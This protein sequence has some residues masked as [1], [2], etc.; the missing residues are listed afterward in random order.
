MHFLGDHSD[1][2]ISERARIQQLAATLF[3]PLIEKKRPLFLSPN[4]LAEHKDKLLLLLEGQ[5]FGC[6]HGNTFASYGRFDLIGL[7]N[8]IGNDAFTV[9]IESPISAIALSVDELFSFLQSDA[10]RLKRW[11][12]WLLLNQSCLQI[13][14]AN[15]V[16]APFEPSAG[17]IHIKA[18]EAIIHEGDEAV[19]V[20]T[21][22]D[23]KA[24][25][26]HQGIKVGDIHP[27]EIFGAL[28]V[29]T[30]QPRM[31]SV[32]ATEDATILAVNKAEFIELI[33]HQ[34][35]ICLGLIEEMA[36]KINELNQQLHSLQA[37]GDKV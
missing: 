29:F 23:G 4:E 1:A 18:G 35:H 11:S 33:D 14:C 24:E 26:R 20:F 30:R 10:Q 16:R 32:I 21:L 28:A 9:S 31:A 27:Q 13:V 5:A 37:I 22:L 15:H 8:I 34:P 3:A 19:D 36:A 12:E 6:Y 25:A 2:C 17:F 7:A